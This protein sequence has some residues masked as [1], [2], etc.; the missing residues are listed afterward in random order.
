MV[1]AIGVG[2][3]R[4]LIASLSVTVGEVGGLS[5]LTFLRSPG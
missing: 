2:D 4:V 3:G 1:I 5:Q